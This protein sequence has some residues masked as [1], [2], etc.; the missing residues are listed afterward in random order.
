[1]NPSNLLIAEKRLLNPMWRLNNLYKIVNKQGLEMLFKCNWA[2]QELYNNLWY[3]NIILKSRQLGISTFVC[4]LFLDRC[5]FNSNVSAGIIAHTLEDAQHIFRRVKFAYDNLPEELRE[6]IKADNDTAGMLRFSNGS[7]LRVG[8]SL[9]SSTFQYLH[10]SEFGK[11]CARY[12]DKAQEIVTGALNTVAPGQYVIIESTAE[13]GSGYFFD[14][15]KQAQD[16]QTAGTKLTELDYKFF[17]FP[18]YKHP[19]YKLCSM[20]EISQDLEEYFDELKSSCGIRLMSEQKAWYVKKYATQADDMKRE[21]PSIPEES[22]QNSTEGLYYGKYFAKIRAEKRI[23]NVSHDETLPVFVAMDLGFNDSTAIWFYQVS[24]QEVHIIDYYENSGEPFTHYLK[25]LKDKPYSIE[26]FYVP[27][28]AKNTEYG[29]GLTRVRIAANHGITLNPLP[30]LSVQEGIDAVRNVLGKCWFDAKKCDK[31][32]KSLE[33]YKKEWNERHGCW[34]DKPVHNFASDGA[35]AFRYMA[36]SL[37]HS[38]N[39]RD[40]ELRH[41]ESLLTAHHFLSPYQHPHFGNFGGGYF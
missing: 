25:V 4:L 10:I 39:E 14:M 3:C 1:M 31:G 28:D 26:K 29:S 41:E 34:N 11:I 8:T 40:A 24:G 37:R 9:R 33:A 38:K 5:L 13:G 6:L 12:P 7:S 20:V 35:D 2:Q 15:C 17:F 21:Y 36:Q 16:L 19:D 32:I 23:C 30:K 22:F 27:H 18:W